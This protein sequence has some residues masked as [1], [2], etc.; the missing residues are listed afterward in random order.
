MND[1][2]QHVHSRPCSQITGVR[3]LVCIAC[4]DLLRTGVAETER[5]GGE[6]AELEKTPARDSLPAHQVVIRVLH[7]APPK[8]SPWPRVQLLRRRRRQVR[9]TRPF[10]TRCKALLLTWINSGPH[11]LQR[12][13][14]RARKDT[15]DAWLRGVVCNASPLHAAA[16]CARPQRPPAV[17]TLPRPGTR[18]L[19]VWHAADA[20]QAGAS[21]GGSSIRMGECWSA[22]EPDATAPRRRQARAQCDSLRRAPRA[23]M[24]R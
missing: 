22:Q 1:S 23:G 15:V 19:D 20:D 5:C 11:W 17:A 21:S 3:V 24:P 4:R 12:G 7:F 2:V 6:A 10:R 13:T 16:C 9:A 18:R 8:E 14:A